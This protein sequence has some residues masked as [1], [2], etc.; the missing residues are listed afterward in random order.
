M[1]IKVYD[2]Q[3]LVDSKIPFRFLNVINNNRYIY[4]GN[5]QNLNEIHGS[6]LTE[7]IKSDEKTISIKTYVLLDDQ[8]T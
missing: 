1:I 5:L 6:L 3:N 8:L 7:D 2:L 4:A